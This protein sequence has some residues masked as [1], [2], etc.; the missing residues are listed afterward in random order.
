MNRRHLVTCLIAALTWTAA[1]ASETP[2]P[3]DIVVGQIGPFTVLPAPDARE[4]NEGL[5]AGLA[6]INTRGG[7]QGR[8]VFLFELDDTYSPEGF[9]KQL[10]AA[11]ERKPVALLSPL[12]SAALKGALDDKLFDNA[13]IVVINAVPGSDVLRAPGHPK[14]FHIRASDKQQIRKIVEHAKSL[15]IQSMAVLHQDL[16]IGTSGLT[17]AQDAAKETGTIQVTGFQASTDANALG[18]AA[19]A[20]AAAGVQS[21]L[22]VGNPKFIGDGIA[23]LRK[24]GFS[25]QLFTL[26][27]M[28][29]PALLKAAGPG[30]RGVGIAQTYPNPIGVNLPLQRDFRAAMKTAHPDQANLT[31]FHLEG[32]ITARI[33]AEAARRSKKITPEGIAQSLHEMGELNLGGFRVNFAKG[34]IGS[35]FVD[36]GVVMPDGKLMY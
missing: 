30:A 15:N 25:Q 5:K 31:T 7:I 2:Q 9:R 35:N 14:L 32:Y 20:M 10:A 24:A 16:P 13:D 29:G 33:F 19:K 17:S 6:E 36:I 1:Q 26:S 4:L 34:N 12:G 22:V 28:P 18:Q 3:N 11:L 27:Y 8:K 21:G 23:A